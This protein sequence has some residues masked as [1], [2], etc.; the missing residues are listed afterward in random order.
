MRPDNQDRCRHDYHDQDCA[1]QF[2]DE[3]RAENPI[4]RFGLADQV[5]NDD[6]EDVRSDR[7]AT[8]GGIAGRHGKT[9]NGTRGGG[10]PQGTN[11]TGGVGAKTSGAAGTTISG[12]NGGDWGTAGTAGTSDVSKTNRAP[13]G[14]AGAAGKAIELSGGAAPTFTG[15]S[16]APHIKGAVS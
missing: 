6:A 13:G 12:A 4:L 10:G 7:A 2:H 11:G 14:P 15:G 16:G 9:G 3:G 5:A 8:R 1:D